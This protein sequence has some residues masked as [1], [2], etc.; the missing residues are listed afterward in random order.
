MKKKKIM[1]AGHI[2]LDITPEFHNSGTQKF[3]EILRQGKLVNVGPAQMTLGGAVS[4]TGLALQKLGADVILTAKI[5]TDLFGD[6]M[7]KKLEEYGCPM[8]LIR[9]EEGA[10]SYTIVLAPKGSDRAFLHDPGS[11][12]TFCADDLDWEEVKKVDY[13]HFGYPTLMRRFYENDGAGLVKLYKAVK[14][15]GLTSSLDLAAVDPE[16]ESGQCDWESILKQVLPYVDFFVPSIEELAYMVD[17]EKYQEWQERAEGEDI[18]SILSLSKDVR[19]LAEKV[20]SYGCGAVLLK[21]GA[22]GMY[23]KTSGKERMRNVDADLEGWENTE[24][25]EDSFVP[26]RILSGTGAGDTSIAAFLY[27]AMQGCTPKESIEYAAATGACC[28][29]TYDTISGLKSFAELRE[30]IQ[31]GWKKQKIMKE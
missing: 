17:R 19:P 29:S 27:A 5:G 18:V 7:M 25:F 1:V 23:L 26:E 20:L 11:N 24:L 15:A 22:A 12:H 21:C 10:T 8:H 16:S 4:N 13:F 6:I 28:V 9:D 31:N 14:T 3:S 2:S 30:K